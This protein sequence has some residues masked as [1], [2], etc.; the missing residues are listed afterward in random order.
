MV[1]GHPPDSDRRL[2]H[3]KSAYG[4]PNSRLTARRPT[5]WQLALGWSKPARRF[6]SP[7]DAC[8]LTSG[9]RADARQPSRERSAASAATGSLEAR[10]GARQRTPLIR[11]KPGT[12]TGLGSG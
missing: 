8:D 2:P 6:G 12:M 9:G 10:K 11:K 7:A 3:S 1:V 4:H 5:G